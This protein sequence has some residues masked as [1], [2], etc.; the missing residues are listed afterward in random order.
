LFVFKH[1]YLI[2]QNS[3]QQAECASKRGEERERG[4]RERVRVRERR[5]L[6][7]H[8]RLLPRAQKHR[9]KSLI[10]RKLVEV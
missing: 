1:F 9:R 10:A 8:L 6:L 5:A 4:G 3:Q 2:F 7:T